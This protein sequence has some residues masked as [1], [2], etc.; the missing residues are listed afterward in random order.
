MRYG[1][2]TNHPGVQGFVFECGNEKNDDMLISPALSVK[3]GKTYRVDYGISLGFYGEYDRIIHHAYNI[4]G[5]TEGNAAAMKDVLAEEPDFMTNENYIDF[6]LTHYFV[7]PV[8]G[9]YYVTLDW[10]TENEAD[11]WIYIMDF[12]FEEIGDHDLEAKEL[13]TH[14]AL[15]IDAENPNVFNVDVYNNGLNAEKDYRVEIGYDF[16]GSFKPFASSDDFEETKAPEVKP[17]E[18][19]TVI[20][21][22]N[23]DVPSNGSTEAEIKARVILDSDNNDV[24]DFTEPVK[25][26]L[27]EG[28]GLTNTFIDE[29][30][31]TEST[32]TPLTHNAIHST[33][34]TIYTPEM[35]GL[36]RNSNNYLRSLA[37]EYS[38]DEDLS[39]SEIEVYL[40]ITGKQ[41][42][43]QKNPAWLGV[44]APVYKGKYDIKKGKNYLH[45]PLA[46]PFEFAGN[47]SLVVTVINKDDINNGFLMRFTNFD[48]YWTLDSFHSLVYTGNERFV[49]TLSASKGSA[50]PQAPVIHASIVSEAGGG[51]VEEVTIGSS[52]NFNPADATVYSLNGVKE[53]RAYDFS[54]NLAG[55]FYAEG[56]ADRVKLNLEKGFYVLRVVENNGTVANLKVSVR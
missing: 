28:P 29:H 41:G 52:V 10:L 33:T 40:G 12:H 19:K 36:D 17:R 27:V 15:G 53:V 35:T 30:L 8:D 25:I 6:P 11:Y 21:I 34:Q 26:S 4:L 45:I 43:K 38:A 9:D 23:P 2:N 13:L 46:T 48:E 14:L 16:N 20:I 50:L 3:K 1:Y 24:N 7:A 47:Q 5:G 37:W 22:G 54:G 49:P 39:G 32:A 51:N 56:A 55:I 18:T 44:S 42:Y 31:V